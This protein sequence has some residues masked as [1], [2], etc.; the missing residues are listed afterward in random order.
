LILNG[1]AAGI[2]A[3][4]QLLDLHYYVIDLGAIIAFVLLLLPAVRSGNDRI[5]TEPQRA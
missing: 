1:L 3:A 5:Q 2:T 4:L